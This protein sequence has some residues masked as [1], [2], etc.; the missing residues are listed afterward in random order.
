MNGF[1]IALAVAASIMVPLAGAAL[2][3]AGLAGEDQIL[4]ATTSRRRLLTIVIGG[5][6]ILSG[7]GCAGI[8]Y[9]Q[10]TN[11]PPQ[12]EQA[13]D[14]VILSILHIVVAGYVVRI[15]RK[16]IAAYNRRVQGDDVLRRVA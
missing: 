7:I 4:E 8:I 10:S 15:V 5:V 16:G 2:V 14:L 6:T 12:S 9:G 1:L 13:F 3:Y 11:V